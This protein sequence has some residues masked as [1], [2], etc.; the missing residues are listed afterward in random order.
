LIR[1]SV[2]E[3]ALAE[4]VSGE[5]QLAGAHVGL[6]RAQRICAPSI[7]LSH[8]HR[9]RGVYGCKREQQSLRRRP[10]EEVEVLEQRVEAVTGGRV[11]GEMGA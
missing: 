8:S 9:L 7:H 4:L 1:E 6:L 11:F 3:V 5:F 2:C 10:H